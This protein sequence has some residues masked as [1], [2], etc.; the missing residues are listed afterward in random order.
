MPGT[1]GARAPVQGTC[2]SAAAACS[3]CGTCTLGISAPHGLQLHPQ[4]HTAPYSLQVPRGPC[5]P[6]GGGR[7]AAPHA[8]AIEPRG[9][10]RGLALMAGCCSCNRRRAPLARWHLWHP[11]VCCNLYA[12]EQARG[13]RASDP[14]SGQPSGRAVSQAAAALQRARTLPDG[15]GPT[16]LTR[17]LGAQPSA[18]WHARDKCH[19][20][21]PGLGAR[22]TAAMRSSLKK[23][24]R[25]LRPPKKRPCR[26]M[27]ALVADSTRSN[28]GG[29][30]GGIQG[31]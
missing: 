23:S 14:R 17:G 26:S 30:Q 5:T 8:A 24:T 18:M 1:L 20:N 22:S 31:C 13:W 3:M 27:S 9:R 6:G 10:A 16:R 7:L 28:C 19:S 29:V 11:A 15:R 12:A 25:T 4:A 21:S 2:A